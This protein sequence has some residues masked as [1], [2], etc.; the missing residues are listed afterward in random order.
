MSELP[1]LQPTPEPST[2]QTL[3][4]GIGLSPAAPDRPADAAKE[5]SVSTSAFEAWLQRMNIFRGQ[6][7]DLVLPPGLPAA[8]EH[9]LLP[10]A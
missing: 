10:L 2:E 6:G 3:Q 1:P 4:P 5:A 9:A 7:A 8:F